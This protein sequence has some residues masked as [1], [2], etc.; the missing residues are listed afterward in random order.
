M[1]VLVVEDEQR[2]VRLLKRVLEDEHYVV[3]T[4]FDGEE[5]IV[6]AGA[7]SYD[8]IILDVMLP[9]RDGVQV[10]SW[11][12]AHQILTPILLLTARDQLEDKITGLD[13]GADDYLTKPFAFEEL[14]ARLRALARRPPA[15]SAQPILQ[16]ADL[17][18]D[19]TR[20]EVK[21][22]GQPIALTMREFALLEYLLR[23]AGQ[24]LSRAQI[25]NH[26]WPYDSDTASN[27]VDIYIHY[28]REKIDYGFEPKLIQTIRGI[29]YTLRG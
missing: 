5:G 2:L 20:H 11:L 19:L 6:K 18:M 1:R 21:R 4:A 25:T 3:D 23:H 22:G 10:C 14:L 28:L 7:G 27:I 24:A 26:V 17:T 9:R 29:G 16:V 8:L 13:A 15:T 12:R